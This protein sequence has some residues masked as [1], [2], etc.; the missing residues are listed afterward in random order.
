VDG[1][2]VDLLVETGSRVHPIEFKLSSTLTPQHVASMK[3]WMKLAGAVAQDGLL[4]STSRTIGP[5][6]DRIASQHYSNL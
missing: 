3:Q 6:S 5:F 1:Y 2:E 4:V